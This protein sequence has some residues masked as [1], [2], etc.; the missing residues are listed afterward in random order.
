MHIRYN[1]TLLQYEYSHTGTDAG[2]WYKLNLNNHSTPIPA[3][4]AYTNVDNIWTPQTNLASQS[5]ISG[6][7]SV[8]WIRET[9]GNAAE[10]RWWRVLSYQNGHLYWER[11]SSAGAYLGGGPVFYADGGLGTPADLSCRNISLAG[12]GLYFPSA[13]I[14]TG[15]ANVLD[16]YE[17]GTWTPSLWSASGGQ[18]TYSI[19]FGMYIKIGKQV[20]YSGRIIITS[21][22]SMVA[23]GQLQIAGF[24]FVFD[25]TSN[26]YHQMNP[27]YFQGLAGNYA[28]FVAAMGFPGTG[29]AYCY[30]TAGATTA[31]GALLTTHIAVSGFEFI[32]SGCGITAS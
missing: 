27:S 1:E 22:G 2:P 32:F 25:S 9:G 14:A 17:E 20:Y 4:I 7:N 18:A 8:F 28:A 16:D 3:N 11:F 31:I 29:I 6:I 24:P 10:P 15:A 12:G 30:Y 23:G 5:G 26:I 13:Q 19:Q 21:K